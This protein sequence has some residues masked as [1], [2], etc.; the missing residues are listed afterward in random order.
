LEELASQSG[1][2]NQFELNEKRFGL[3]SH[4]KEEMYTTQLN[5]EKVSTTLLEKA[6]RIEAVI[7]FFYYNQKNLR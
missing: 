2:W 4:F 1:K 3:T 5:M 6:A 7:S